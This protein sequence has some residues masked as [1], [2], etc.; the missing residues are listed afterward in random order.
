MRS[1]KSPASRALDVD[2]AE[3][4]DVADAD[5]G[6]HRAHLAPDASRASRSRPAADNIGRAA[7]RRFRRTPRP[8]PAPIDATAAAAS[9]GSPCRGGVR[10]ERRARPACRAGERWSC[11]LAGSAGSTSSARIARP[12]TFADLALVGRHAERGVALE[13]LDRSKA[14]AL[15]ER[16]IVDGDVVL[17]IDEGLAGSLDPPQRRDGDRLVLGAWRRGRPRGEAAVGRGRRRRLRRR[18]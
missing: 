11:R 7:R 16:D 13:M 18:S 12:V 1:R 4:R 14:L 5:R 9:G 8:A 6:T 2:L 10:R 3:R 15:G 17:E